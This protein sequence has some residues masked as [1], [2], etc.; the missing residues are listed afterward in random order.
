M[1]SFKARGRSDAAVSASVRT[2][3]EERK[4]FESSPW[5]RQFGFSSSSLVVNLSLAA[6]KFSSSL[7]EEKPNWQR[8]VDFKSYPQ[9]LG[10][11]KGVKIL[12]HLLRFS[13]SAMLTASPPRNNPCI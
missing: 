7:L 4:H 13:S 11:P 5:A 3:N 12:P 6:D 9:S 2:S 1:F 10:F 8:W